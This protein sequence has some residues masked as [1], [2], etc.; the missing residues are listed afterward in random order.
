MLEKSKRRTKVKNV[1]MQ[2]VQKLLLWRKELNEKLKGTK[3]SCTLHPKQTEPCASCPHH[4]ECHHYEWE[5]DYIH[6]QEQSTKGAKMRE[7]RGGKIEQKQK[8]S[9]SHEDH[10]PAYPCEPFDFCCPDKES[11]QEGRQCPWKT[12]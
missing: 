1:D 8:I 6:K 2:M 4:K 3:H 9:Q 7:K 12:E 10:G 11:C 5:R